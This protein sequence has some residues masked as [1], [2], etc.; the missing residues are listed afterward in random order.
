MINLVVNWTQVSDMHEVNGGFIKGKKIQQL[1]LKPLFKFN[2]K[3]IRVTT[4]HSM[5]I[6]FQSIDLEILEQNNIEQGSS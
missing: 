6:F 3:Y 5:K 2:T 1:S 4:T